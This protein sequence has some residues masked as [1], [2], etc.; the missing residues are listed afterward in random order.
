MIKAGFIILTLLLATL[1]YTGIALVSVKALSDVRKQKQF[2]ARSLAILVGW[3]T[4]VSLLSLTGIFTT[5]TLPPRVPLMLILPCLIFIFWF[6]KSNRFNNF[7]DATPPEWLVY[8]QSSRIFVEVLLLGMYAKGMIPKASTLE[9]Y[10]YEIVIG[11]SAFA[12]GYYGYNKRLIPRN[13]II[14]WNFVGNLTLAIIGFIM[15]SHA[16]F[17]HIYT[18]P[19]HLSI[20]EFGS[21]PY[22][23]FAGFIA[24][25]AI[26]MHIFSIIKTKR[27]FGMQEDLAG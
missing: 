23:L 3:L 20:K 5:A 9:G 6:F 27:Y 16:Y 25:L 24:P 7:I 11:L 18:N 12:V 1:V 21:F 8:M 4:Y 19:G 15:I 22:T 2:K 10:N 14:A 17:P 26:F 13:V